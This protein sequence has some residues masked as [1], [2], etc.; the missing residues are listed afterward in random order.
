VNRDLD[1]FRVLVV[2]SLATMAL[3][4]Y[5]AFNAA[6]PSLEAQAF[7]V[8]QGYGAVLPGFI[9]FYWRWVEIGLYAIALA[10]M[11]FFWQFSRQLM[12]IAL[13]L[14]PIRVALGGIWISSP[15]ED[16]FW[17][18]HWIFVVFVIGMA[19]FQPAVRAAF[20]RPADEAGASPP[21]TSLERTRDR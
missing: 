12:L 14:S 8:W 1:N 7:Y 16:S 21:N 2:L 17:S 9:D 19:F 3:A 18:F 6:P 4:I 11:F 5:A 15:L 13:F 10:S 20:T